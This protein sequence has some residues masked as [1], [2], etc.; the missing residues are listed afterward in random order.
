MEEMLSVE[1]FAKRLGGIS[2]ATV[3]TW[4]SLGRFGLRRTKVGSRTMLAAS[5]LQKVIDGSVRP[6]RSRAK[7][8]KA[9]A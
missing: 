8:Q 6:I 7:R 1:E 4:L 9:E 2:A 5:E 3:H